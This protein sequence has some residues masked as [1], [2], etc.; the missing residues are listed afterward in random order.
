[1]HDMRALREQVDLLRDAMR[2][3]GADEGLLQL[4]DRGESLDRERRTLIQAR[5][6]LRPRKRTRHRLHRRLH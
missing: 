3:R 4:I 1:M 6:R 2:R 5:Q